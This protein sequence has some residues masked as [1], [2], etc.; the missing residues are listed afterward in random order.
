MASND[1]LRAELANWL[2]G[3]VLKLA[4]AKP[5]VPTVV[6]NIV[7]LGTVVPPLLVPS[8][9]GCSSSSSSNVSQD[10]Q[11]GPPRVSFSQSVPPPVFFVGERTTLATHF[12]SPIAQHAE[13][14]QWLQELSVL[15]PY[16]RILCVVTVCQPIF[17]RLCLDRQWEQPR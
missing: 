4:N 3:L 16:D 8:S 10:N 9:Q 2:N 17:R 15:Q 13:V 5:A 12:L 7:P 11:T 14:C 6:R 1:E